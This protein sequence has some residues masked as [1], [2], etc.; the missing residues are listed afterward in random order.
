[1]V[2]GML[3]GP[4]YDYGYL[5]SLVVIGSVLSVLG[6]MLTS[7]CTE[8]WQVLLSQGFLLGIGSGCLFA[9]SV[10]VLPQY[11]DKKQPLVMGIA[12]SGSAL[13]T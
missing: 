13:G 10:A 5:R 7:L 3:S 6:I 2:L 1:M 4:L 12:A 9:P 8:Y 11:F